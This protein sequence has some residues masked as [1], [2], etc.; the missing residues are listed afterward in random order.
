[1]GNPSPSP[2]QLELLRAV[3]F[4]GGTLQVPSH[5][6]VTTIRVVI[7]KGWAESSNSGLRI[8]VRGRRL[9]GESS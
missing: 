6:R 3:A 5:F 8:T 7:A 1:V 9:I 2:E 4:A